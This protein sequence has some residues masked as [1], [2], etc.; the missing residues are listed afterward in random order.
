MSNEWSSPY[1]PFNSM[2]AL[3]HAKNFEAILEENPLPPIVVNFDLTNKCNYNCR[4]CMFSENRERADKT[5]ELFREGRE[6][7][8]EAYALTLPK[9]WK[10]WGVK[11][12]CLAG[13][14]EPTLHSDYLPFIKECIFIVNDGYRM[15]K[16][17]I[18]MQGAIFLDDTTDNLNSSNADIKICVGNKYP[19]NDKWD[20]IRCYNWTDIKTLLI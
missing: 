11:A 18:N 5:G 8:P 3:T 17:S 20:G 13:G 15:D 19:W 2:K 4:F 10:D 9:L 12:V 6:S 1:N 14:G 7:L 16:S